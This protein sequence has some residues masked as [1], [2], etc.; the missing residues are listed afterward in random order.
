MSCPHVEW[1]IISKLLFE[2]IEL[3]S[4]NLY[5]RQILDVEIVKK[6]VCS[7]QTNDLAIRLQFFNCGQRAGSTIVLSITQ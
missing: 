4:G 5:Y 2:N 7:Y 3:I 1:Q 6:P